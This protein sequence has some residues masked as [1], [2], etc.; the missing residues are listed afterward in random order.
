MPDLSVVFIVSQQR[1][2]TASVPRDVPANLV[3]DRGAFVMGLVP[4]G[5]TLEPGESERLRQHI[6][7]WGRNR[8]DHMVTV[9]VWRHA[10]NA[11]QP[12]AAACPRCEASEKQ[13]KNAEAAGKQ[14]RIRVQEALKK[15]GELEG[16][17]GHAAAAHEQQIAELRSQS[18]AAARGLEGQLD[19]ARADRDRYRDERDA[20]EVQRGRLQGDL[21]E[22]ERALAECRRN[23]ET[24]VTRMRERLERL[25]REVLAAAD[26]VEDR[27]LV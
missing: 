21:E 2:A 26:E 25:S 24:T 22:A 27:A 13:A 4:D 19:A 14:A 7:V 5:F 16:A 17:L 11:P 3:G 15:I 20:A 9:K 23:A 12:A 1:V 18:D 10:M 8:Q 6:D